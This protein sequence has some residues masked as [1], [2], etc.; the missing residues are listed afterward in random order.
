MNNSMTTS[1]MEAKM[2]QEQYERN[3]PSAPLQPYLD[4]RPVSTKY[5]LLPIVDPRKKVNVP[6]AVQPTYH[7]NV[8][9]NPGNAS[10]PWS[11]YASAVNV[12]SELKNQV[13]ALQNCDRSAYVPNSNSDLYQVRMPISGTMHQPHSLLFKQE[14]FN[15]C[16]PTPSY[17]N[18]TMFFNSTRCDLKC[19]H[20]KTT[21]SKGDEI[22]EETKKG[23]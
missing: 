19:S 18:N 6:M 9:F 7:T 13:F 22:T 12:E 4:V 23:N 10:G 8:T 11:G 15:Y 2:N 14:K 16:D 1:Q 5:S 21:L 17:A 3:I 20:E